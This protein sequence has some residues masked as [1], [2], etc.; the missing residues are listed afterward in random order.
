MREIDYKT[1]MTTLKK[2]KL[3]NE[4]DDQK[5]IDKSIGQFRKT[6]EHVHK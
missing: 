3:K 2:A 6:K 1:R 5:N 4:S